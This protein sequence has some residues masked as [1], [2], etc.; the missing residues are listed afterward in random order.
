MHG[1]NSQSTFKNRANS[2]IIWQNS[3]K[4]VVEANY[5]RKILEIL[6][7]KYIPEYFRISELEIT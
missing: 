3:S 6:L 4:H 2:G 5:K 1:K 7:L